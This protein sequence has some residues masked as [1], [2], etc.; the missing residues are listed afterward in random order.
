MN[1]QRRQHGRPFF[2]VEQHFNREPRRGPRLYKRVSPSVCPSIRPSVTLYFQFAEKDNK[3]GRDKI[4]IRRTCVRVEMLS[5]YQLAKESIF[6]HRTKYQLP[7]FCCMVRGFWLREKCQTRNC[8]LRS[9]KF[10]SPDSRYTN[11]KSAE[12]RDEFEYQFSA[13]L[14]VGHGSITV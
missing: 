5:T 3:T 1:Y 14:V 2:L 7:V 6:W 8:L 9:T 13:F 10:R 11:D 12:R 4:V